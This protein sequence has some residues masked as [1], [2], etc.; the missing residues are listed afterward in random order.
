LCLYPHS[1]RVMIYRQVSIVRRLAVLDDGQTTLSYWQITR[2]GY[3]RGIVKIIP[4][5]P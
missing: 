2:E 3:H 1:L 5:L 4:E